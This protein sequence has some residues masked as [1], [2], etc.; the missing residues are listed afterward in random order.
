LKEKKKEAFKDSVLKKAIDL[1]GSRKWDPE[2]KNILGK[3]NDKIYDY[4]KGVC[5]V[6]YLLSMEFIPV[7]SKAKYKKIKILEEEKYLK[8][9]K[10]ISPHIIADAIDSIALVWL[11]TWDKYFKLDRDA[12]KKKKQIKNRRM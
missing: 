5:L 3:G 12:K 1:L 4:T 7:M 8:R 9:L 2:D 11:L 10:E 6:S